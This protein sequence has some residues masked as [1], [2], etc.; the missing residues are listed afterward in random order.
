MWI[1]GAVV[2]AGIAVALVRTY[3]LLQYWENFVRGMEHL[4]AALLILLMAILP[5]GGFS[6]SVVYLLAG[7]KFGPVWGGVVV[8]FVTAFHLVS[9]HV[10]GRGFLRQRLERFLK[11]KKYHLPVIPKGEDGAVAT[12][13][14]LVPGPPY[15]A[16]NYLLALTGIPLRNYFWICLGIYLAR[17]YVVILFGDLSGDLTTKRMVIFGCVYGVKLSVCAYVIARLRRRYGHPPRNRHP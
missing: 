2:A 1:L 7:A 5:L 14:A 4:D 11:K 17:S 10:I 15:F 12:M 3:N 6:I 8:A 9:M 13:A 16:R